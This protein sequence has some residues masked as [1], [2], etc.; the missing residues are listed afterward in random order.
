MK[1]RIKTDR[2]YWR[3]A[4]PM[5]STFME[6][7]YERY[8]GPFGGALA[9]AVL[10]EFQTWLQEK[11]NLTPEPELGIAFLTFYN[12]LRALDYTLPKSTDWA[13]T[14]VT[15]IRKRDGKNL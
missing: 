8:E 9:Q 10:R 5:L 2:E 1:Q 12:A 13:K 7:R 4:S 15:G 3:Q 11:H 14:R 6:E